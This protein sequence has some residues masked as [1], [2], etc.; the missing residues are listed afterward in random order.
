MNVIINDQITEIPEPSSLNQL[1]QFIGQSGH[2]A[3]A[4]NQIFVPKQD[5]PK[6]T[7]N[8]D[9]VIDIVEPMSGG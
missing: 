4:V 7:I 6:T 9:D 5:H 1:L 3:V 2:F 8:P